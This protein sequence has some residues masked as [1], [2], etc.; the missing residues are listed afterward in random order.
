M[1]IS[2]WGGDFVRRFLGQDIMPR[3]LY[4]RLFRTYGVPP[5]PLQRQSYAA[6]K[7][8]ELDDLHP[9]ELESPESLVRQTSSIKVVVIGAGLAGLTAAWWLARHGFQVTVLEANADV[10][11]RV[12]SKNSRLSRVIEAGGELIGRNHPTWL[13]FARRFS[14]ALSVLTTEDQYE[15]AKLQTP[16]VLG[17]QQLSRKQQQQVFNEMTDA[18]AT[19]NADATQVN[20]YHPWTAAGAV[21]WDRRTVANWLSLIAT[22]YS[23]QTNDALRFELENNQA[24]PATNQ[25]YLGLLAAVKGGSLTP[26]SLPGRGPSEFWTESEVFRCASGNQQLAHELRSEI[27]K[28]NGQVLLSSPVNDVDFGAVNGKVVNGTH[29]A[30]W[31]ILAVPPSVWHKITFNTPLPQAM[32]MGDAVKYLAD[33][34]NRFW[35]HQGHA[36]SGT[37]NSL[38]MLWEGT[39]NQNLP[40][41]SGA[42]LSVFAGAGVAQKALQASNVDLYFQTAIEAVYKGF[43]NSF[44]AGDF[45]SWPTESWIR[46]GYSC[47]ASGQVSTVARALY[48]PPGQLLFAGEHTCM[49][50]FGYMEGALQS[51]LHTALLIARNVGIPQAATWWQRKQA[52]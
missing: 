40:V 6:S 48:D 25:S 14:L 13:S 50:F 52:E 10:G 35:L 38:G 3:S 27:Q 51:G 22:K 21:Q 11:G 18:L 1:S 7:A 45:R 4:S 32:Q 9:L 28:F 46:A 47:P 24:V 20:A 39:D 29:P 30:D 23:P 44:A 12:L 49:A 31:V 34:N 42:E 15:Y 41:G 16:L 37:D 8:E 2:D 33:I 17:G 5:T 19:L 36:P 43:K 26:L